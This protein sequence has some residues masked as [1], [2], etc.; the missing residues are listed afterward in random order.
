METLAS[1]QLRPRNQT[2]GNRREGTDA[3]RMGGSHGLVRHGTAYRPALSKSIEI[4]RGVFH[5]SIGIGESF[6]LSRNLGVF[7]GTLHK[8]QS[9]DS[10]A[11]LPV[12]SLR[13]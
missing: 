12:P 2:R 4:I 11:L 9:S 6:A 3:R 8:C 1:K 5:P 10:R 13:D 7:C